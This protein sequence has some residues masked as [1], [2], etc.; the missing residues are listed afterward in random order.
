MRETA[1]K[2]LKA[3]RRAFGAAICGIP[4]LASLP[5]LAHP[6]GD[7]V[8]GLAS[9]LAHPLSGL[10]HLLA[11]VAVG[12]LAGQARG[13]AVW[14][15]PVAFVAAML[16]GAGLGFGGVVLPLVEPTILASVLILGG[17]ILTAF[18]LP[19]WAGPLLVAGFGVF[20]GNAHGIELAT[21][22]SA[23][24]FAAGFVVSTSAL[25][26]SGLAFVLLGRRLG[27][28]PRALRLTRL[29]GAAIFAAGGALVFG[30]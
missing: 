7:S 12:L 17:L 16:A 15:T 22:D 8:A 28:R 25:H 1:L 13:R 29:A 30:V 20:H 19:V 27:G 11:M 21:G 23:L 18:S 4:A 10:D 9:G 6:G 26:A 5:A 14:S 24:A 2:T 3:V